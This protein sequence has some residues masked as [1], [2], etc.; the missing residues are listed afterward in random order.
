MVGRL[1]QVVLK[2]IHNHTCTICITCYT[3]HIADITN[4]TAKNKSYDNRKTRMGRPSTTR[5]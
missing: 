3:K 2:V 5:R 4:N 1:E